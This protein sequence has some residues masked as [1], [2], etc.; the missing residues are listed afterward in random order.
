MDPTP[1]KPVKKRRR[2]LIF[3]LVLVLAGAAWWNW[4][5]GDARF[6]GKWTATTI[7]S[8]DAPEVW[9]FSRNGMG[10]LFYPKVGCT[11]TFPWRLER[12][13]FSMGYDTAGFEDVA[14]WTTLQ[15]LNAMDWSV[16]TGMNRYTV[17]EI[18][19]DEIRLQGGESITV[20]RRMPE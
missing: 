1:A 10:L 9:T 6:V 3:T 17:Q 16:M 13:S 7:G 4:P 2:W 8:P 14:D 15:A 11:L 20:L 19:R 18:S 12:T 5:R